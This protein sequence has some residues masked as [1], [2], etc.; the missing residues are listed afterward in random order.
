MTVTAKLTDAP[1]DRYKNWNHIPWQTVE[2]DV[3][4]LQERIAK[5]VKD[6]NYRKAKAL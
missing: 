6:K 3:R 2:Q 4:R 5:A 1:S